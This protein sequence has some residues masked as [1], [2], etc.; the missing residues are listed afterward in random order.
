MLHPMLVVTFGVIFT[1]MS[2]SRFLAGSCRGDG[3]NSVLENVAKLKSLHE[4]PK[5]MKVQ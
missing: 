5:K 4:V 1:S 3:L 2:T